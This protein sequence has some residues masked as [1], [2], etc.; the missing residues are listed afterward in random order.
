MGQLVGFT[1]LTGGN[2]AAPTASVGLVAVPGAAVTAMRS[3]AA[4]ALDIAI[5]PTWTGLHNFANATGL[6]MITTAGAVTPFAE[7]PDFIAERS[8]KIIRANSPNLMGVAYGSTG[9]LSVPAALT[10]GDFIFAHKGRG[11]DGAAFTGDRVEM[12]YIATE[13]WNAGANGTRIDFIVTRNGTTVPGGIA[14][15][16][17]TNVAG[18]MGLMLFD[19]SAGNI[20][21]VSRGA[22]DSGGAG[23]RLLRVP[24]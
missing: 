10:N 24:N 19:V 4:P 2:F 5:A 18:D 14:R 11:Y 6:R 13:N 16:E 21:Q 22:A 9:S 15:F 3:D 20:V 8:I 7:A 12:R 17:N 1:T 23:F